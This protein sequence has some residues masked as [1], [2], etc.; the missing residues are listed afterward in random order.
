MLQDSSPIVTS[1]THHV[2]K[3]A[4]MFICR[5]QVFIPK[6][7]RQTKEA[8]KNEYFKVFLYNL[9]LLWLL[10]C[11]HCYQCWQ[12]KG[13]ILVSTLDKLMQCKWWLLLPAVKFVMCSSTGIEDHPS[14]G[15]SLPPPE[16][17]GCK[18]LP[19]AGDSTAQ[20]WW[21][22]GENRGLR[23]HT[24]W[25]WYSPDPVIIIITQDLICFLF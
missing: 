22:T 19:Q 11:L 9:P 7:H 24:L 16:G 14:D 5:T 17:Q 13:I 1:A 3:A 6:Q 25:T 2:S 23:N 20:G 18:L 8:E 21:Q 10:T 15:L 4:C 12:R